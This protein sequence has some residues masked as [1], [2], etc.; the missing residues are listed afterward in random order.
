MTIPIVDDG[1]ETQ[2]EFSVDVEYEPT[3]TARART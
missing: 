1:T 2:H 3:F